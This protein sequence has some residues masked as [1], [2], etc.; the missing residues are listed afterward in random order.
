MPKK[1][2]SAEFK[3]RAVRMVFVTRGKNPTQATPPRV[4]S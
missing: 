3:D 2:Y 1:K 4:S